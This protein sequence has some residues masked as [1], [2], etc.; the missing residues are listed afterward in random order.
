MPQGFPVSLVMLIA[1][2]VLLYFMTIRPQKKRQEEMQKVRNSLK[3]GDQVVTIGGLRGKIVSLTDDAF[4]IES[5]SQ[6]SQ[7]EFLRS[8]L[9]YVVTPAPGYHSE[10]IVENAEVVEESEEDHD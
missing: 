5:G 10:E 7:L 3:V 6:G 1:M 4:V 8:A 9:S 2:F